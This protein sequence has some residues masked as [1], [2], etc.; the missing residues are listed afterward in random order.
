MRKPIALAALAAAVAATAV[1]AALAAP[2][3]V[4][5]GDNFFVRKH[6]KPTVTVDRGARVR[7]VWVGKNTHNVRVAKGPRKFRSPYRSSGR[8]TTKRLTV[9]GTYTLVCDVHPDVMRMTLRVR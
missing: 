7:F 9:R 4:R 2:R 8:Y 3:S 5:V 1:P 6:A